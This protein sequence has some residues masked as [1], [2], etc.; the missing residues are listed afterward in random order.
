MP[1]DAVMINSTEPPARRPIALVLL[2]HGPQS[3]LMLPGG[4]KVCQCVTTRACAHKKMAPKP[5]ALVVSQSGM[6]VVVTAGTAVPSRM[7]L[8]LHCREAEHGR[9][10]QQVVVHGRAN[11][12]KAG[13][14]ATCAENSTHQL[15]EPSPMAPELLE[16]R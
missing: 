7:R 5:H 13:G 16:S 3:M 1:R 11:T 14:A 15:P 8:G 4:L 2:S 12:A 9:L 6:K 10:A